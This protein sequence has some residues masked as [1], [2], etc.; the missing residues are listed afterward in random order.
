[1]NRQFLLL[2]VPWLLIGLCISAKAA[3]SSVDNEFAGKRQ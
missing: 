1:M 3:E 2:M